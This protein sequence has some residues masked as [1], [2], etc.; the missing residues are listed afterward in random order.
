M[1]FGSAQKVILV[2]LSA[3]FV[4]FTFD[5]L[6]EQIEAIDMNQTTVE[7]YKNMLGK[8]YSFWTNVSMA[9]GPNPLTWWLPTTP[10]LSQIN[11]LELLYYE[12]EV[13]SNHKLFT[14]LEFKF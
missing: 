1:D 6:Y 12:N 5:F 4:F 9:F 2:L 11:V 13:F 8:P 14:I 10:D 3:F 7:T